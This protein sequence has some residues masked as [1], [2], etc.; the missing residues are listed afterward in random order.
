MNNNIEHKVDFDEYADDYEQLLKDQLKFFNEDRSYFSKYKIDLVK[1]ECIKNL[2]KPKKILEFG[3]GIG[4]NIPFIEKGFPDSK[5]YVSDISNKSLKY[6]NKKYKKVKVLNDNDIEKYKYDFIFVAGVIHHIH[7]KLRNDVIKRL[8]FILK[9]E[10][11][12]FVFEH[13]PYNP[14]TRHM[15]NTCP[16]DEDAVL[17][18]MKDMKSDFLKNS[19]FKVKSSG[20]C[21]YFPERFKF[22]NGLENILKYIPLGGQYYVCFQPS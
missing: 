8:L 11:S 22:M 14:V 18:K 13:N 10:G 20:Y 1:K 16:F 19:A 15:V 5:I 17:I 3:C 6:V 9:P 7:P 21:L 12:L 2:I 4:L